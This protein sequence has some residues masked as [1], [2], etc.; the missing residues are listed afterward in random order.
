MNNVPLTPPKYLATSFNC[1]SCGAFAEQVWGGG[2]FSVPLSGPKIHQTHSGIDNIALCQCQHCQK[3]SIWIDCKIIFPDQALAPLPA[4]DLPE[5]IKKD[6][7]E[8]RKTINVSP[9]GAAA[10]LRLCV[11]KLCK[12]LGGKGKDLNSDIAELVKRGLNVQIQKSLDAVR[13]IGN[14]AVHPGVMD[15]RDDS[16]S[17]VKLC[18]L[19]NIITEAMITQPAEIDAIYSSLPKDKIAQIDKRD[20]K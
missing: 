7:L 8:A 10:L 6:F 12:H 18:K 5:D 9:R 11:Q 1:P 13:V 4:L 20:G 2:C 19:I 17:A 15:L 14:E 3:H 16:D